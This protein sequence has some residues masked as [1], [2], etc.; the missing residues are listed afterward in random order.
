MRR[1]FSVALF[2][3]SVVIAGCGKGGGSNPVIT[4]SGANGDGTSG[5]AGNGGPAG[6][7]GG[8]V[9]ANYAKYEK[10]IADAVRL[11]GSM[12]SEYNSLAQSGKAVVT[13]KQSPRLVDELQDVDTKLLFL[14]SPT[15]ADAAKLKQ[16]S[17]PRLIEAIKQA[18]LADS[19]F[20]RKYRST[21]GG[22]DLRRSVDRTKRML[23]RLQ[24]AL[25]LAERLTFGAP[26][27]V[28]GQLRANAS[29]G[30]LIKL[31]FDPDDY[32]STRRR[33]G[34]KPRE[35]VPWQ[36]TV[37]ET[38]LEVDLPS[39]ARLGI[40]IPHLNARGSFRVQPKKI[41]YPATPSV[42][43][44][45]GLNQTTAQTRTVWDLKAR[46]RLGTIKG[47]QMN[48]THSLAISPDGKFFAGRPEGTNIIGIWDIAA[49]KA[50]K[51]INLP[52]DSKTTLLEFAADNRIV[53]VVD[54]KLY[55]LQ[56]PSGT[57]EREIDLGRSVPASPFHGGTAWAISP[58]GKYLAIPDP[59]GNDVLF[60]DVTTGEK[61]GRIDV[62][63]E[64]GVG[65]I[66]I[67]FANDGKRAAITI[68]AAFHSEVQIWDISTGRPV[69]SF[70]FEKSLFSLVEGDRAYQGPSVDW[71]PDHRRLLVYG[72]GIF[73]SESG[74]IDKV[75]PSST[76]YRLQPLAD[77]QL[78]IV[79]GGK[80]APYDLGTVNSI[81]I[82]A[83]RAET[84]SSAA[85]GTA[86]PAEES[87][88]LLVE[89]DRSERVVVQASA[90]ASWNVEIDP[91]P[92]VSIG[93]V[94][95]PN[96][97]PTSPFKDSITHVAVA[98]SGKRAAVGYSS[99]HLRLW[100]GKI[101][102]PDEARTW[103]AHFDPAATANATRLTLPFPA[104]L[105]TISPSGNVLCT[106][107]LKELGRLDFWNTKTNQ[108]EFGFQPYPGGANGDGLDVIWADYVGEQRLLTMKAGQ[109]TLWQLP[110]C[111]AV[112]ETQVSTSSRPVFSPGR[113]YLAVAVSDDT[114]RRCRFIRCDD[115]ESAGQIELNEVSGEL[116]AFAFARDGSR[117]AFVSSTPT[118]G[119]VTLADVAT[120]QVEEPFAVPVTGSVAE[121]AGND[122]LLID[123]TFLVSLPQKV[124]AWRYDL[125]PGVHV[126]D[127]PDGRHWYLTSSSATRD[128]P[129]IMTAV[130][131]PDTNAAS[132]IA[133]GQLERHVAL[134][135]GGR[136]RLDIQV[137]N[138]PGRANFGQQVA[139]SFS[140]SFQAAGITVD[141]SAP[142]QVTVR[143]KSEKTGSTLSN[144][145]EEMIAYYTISIMEGDQL[146]WRQ[147]VS[148]SNAPT[149]SRTRSPNGSQPAAPVGNPMWEKAASNL[150]N[151]SVP[152]YVFGTKAARGLGKSNFTPTGTTLGRLRQ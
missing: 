119:Y 120:G 52:P 126:A 116:T 112:W 9:S 146:L 31:G 149:V 29:F 96:L 108:R 16:G 98:A 130:E 41:L 103:I 60:V 22:D 106:K 49:A 92:A 143:G 53:T 89:A 110:D 90:P 4:G 39:A 77:D 13:I 21:F 26:Y 80:L 62:T 6:S 140:K 70:Q 151:L 150:L 99:D 33:P 69:S 12:S 76:V 3:F 144:G 79:E 138:P 129:F 7:Q 37:D 78:I 88:P 94:R 45:V 105:Q 54:T 19:R 85:T 139:D 61:A 124:F 93:N 100:S 148:G 35:S 134:Q 122:H 71:F 147:S 17:L 15:A 5:S 117:L 23:A 114:K 24:Q 136:V 58:G 40:D 135:P 131:L 109:L 20:R 107:S 66:A 142:V 137:S 2:C 30:D 27:S 38:P 104:M 51:T 125:N 68:D 127:S 11:L 48:A 1:A 43:V 133:A 152:T 132:A 113:Q 83:T 87:D 50:V 118:V 75:L 82:S 10:G 145:G 28:G 102:H 121:W 101:Y 42:C 25:P 141:T 91:A 128:A 74:A 95:V 14:D 34:T 55:I 8:S 123:G 81:T 47:M 57:L 86:K 32:Q 44:A 67:D 64:F 46:K 65:W 115:G 18:M 84:K 72:R 73:D 56:T 36:V 97:K 111:R 59:R 63:E